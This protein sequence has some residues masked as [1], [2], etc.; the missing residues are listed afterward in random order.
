MEFMIFGAV[1]YGIGAG[2][3][4]IGNWVDNHWGHIQTTMPR[5][6]G[7]CP[8]T[9]T[10]YDPVTKTHFVGIALAYIILGIAWVL[11]IIGGMFGIVGFCVSFI[12]FIRSI[13]KWSNQIER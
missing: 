9:W 4:W 11:E 13:N 7:I 2:S 12:S 10:V 6:V 3:E 8:F 5:K 1:I